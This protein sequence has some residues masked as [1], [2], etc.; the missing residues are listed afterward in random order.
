MNNL[1]KI[2]KILGVTFVLVASSNAMAATAPSTVTATVQNA[3]LLGEDTALDFGTVRATADPV[4]VANIATLVLAADGTTSTA[5]V[6]NSNMTQ[7]LPGSVGAFTVTQ[8]APFTNLT[9]TFP[10]DF[11]LTATGAPP[12]S[13]IFDV[14]N[15]DWTAIVRG[16]ANDGAVYADAGPGTGNLQ[17]DNLG[18]VSF[19]VGTSLKTDT[20]V[21]TTTYIDA[22]YV[23]SYTMT[24]D[25]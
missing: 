17:T 10:A 22:P 11:T 18:S 4:G 12:T 7:L 19:D 1:N 21:T 14:L 2:T 9:I 16:G 13:P 6:G 15:A 25:Y 3:F 5:A 23:G 24:V 20:A 8:A